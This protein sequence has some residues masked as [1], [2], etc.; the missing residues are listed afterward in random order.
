MLTA[1]LINGAW[2]ATI[3]FFAFPGMDVFARP[4]TLLDLARLAVAAFFAWGLFECLIG[5]GYDG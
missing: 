5:K 1:R 3:M 4:V 2:N